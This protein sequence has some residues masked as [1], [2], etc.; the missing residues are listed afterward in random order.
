MLAEQYARRVFAAGNEQGI[1]LLKIVEAAAK[2]AQN[3]AVMIMPPMI[4][5]AKKAA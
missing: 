5:V 1:R 4:W 2:D 3:G